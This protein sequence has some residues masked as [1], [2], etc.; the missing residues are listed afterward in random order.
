MAVTLNVNAVNSFDA[1]RDASSQCQRW[2]RWLRSFELCGCVGC[3]RT[4]DTQ[5]R[6]LLLHCAGESIQDMFFTLADTG[7]TY[8]SAK[9]KI[10]AYFTPRK[11]TSYNRHMFRK[12][13][14]N[15]EESV[16]QYV[17]RL[18]QLAHLCE[19]GDQGD[20]FIRDQVIDNGRS[21]RLRTK[22]LAER[23]LNL[24]RVL[25]LAGAMEAS[26]SQAAQISEGGE[27]SYM[28]YG[29]KQSGRY[30]QQT[31]QKNQKRQPRHFHSNDSSR[32][33]E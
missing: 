20:D 5:K 28:V 30:T 8:E 19:F 14:Q 9:A 7:N 4:D 12:A 21:K 13:C 25:D 11:N 10:T 18:R 23:D 33:A 29:K 24:D 6:Q 15:D 1:Q 26:E 31:V 17:T 2:Q 3:H 27:R 16:A 22:L 32:Y